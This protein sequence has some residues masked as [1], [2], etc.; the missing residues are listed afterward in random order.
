MRHAE[1]MPF[2]VRGMGFFQTIRSCVYDPV[3][4]S[5][6]RERSWTDAAKY[7]AVVSFIIVFA[8][9]APVWGLL[10]NAR[11]ELVDR[12]VAVYP[13]GLEVT[14]A[15]GEMS[16]NRDE[17]FVIPNTFTKELPSN[18]VVFDT[19]NDEFAP[20]ALHDADT[21][22]LF[23]NTFAITANTDN[24]TLANSGE[25]RIFSYGTSTGTSTLVKADIIA[26]AE[27]IKPYVR[28]VAI[29]GGAFAFVLAVLLGG[30]GMLV[31][32]LLY[33]LFPALFVYFY[34]KLR[35]RH[36]VFKT[37]YTTALFAS[38]PVTIVFSMLGLF[39][40]VPAFSYTLVLLLIVIANDARTKESENSTQV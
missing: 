3:F 29:I 31:F 13:D 6:M 28:P 19:G 33:T 18:L 20:S 17:P 36:D 39:I 1:T 24:P 34:F 11:P 30:A 25:Q 2:R 4:Y 32:H 26:V 27:S 15:N 37:A 8:V 40:A 16:I 35:K 22:V 14:L 10:L 21:L 5:G 23:K 38:I 7:Y 9:L 12:A